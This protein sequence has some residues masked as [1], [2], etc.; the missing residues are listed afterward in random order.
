MSVSRRRGTMVKLVRLVRCCFLIAVS[1]IALQVNLGFASDDSG[2]DQTPKPFVK[3]A[4]WF[5]RSILRDVQ[6]AEGER[7]LVAKALYFNCKS[8]ADA[9]ADVVAGTKVQIE[10]ALEFGKRVLRFAI[11]RD[12]ISRATKYWEIAQ[13]AHNKKEYAEAVD[14]YLRAIHYNGEMWR[15]YD[16]IADI[17]LTPVS[18]FYSPKRAFLMSRLGLLISPREPSLHH[19]YLR[20]LLHLKL[21]D[22]ALRSADKAMA[23]SKWESAGWSEFKGDR[24]RCKLVARKAQALWAQKRKDAAERYF[25]IAQ[26]LDKYS[27]VKWVGAFLGGSYVLG[28]LGFGVAEDVPG[29]GELVVESSPWSDILVSFLGETTQKDGIELR[30]ASIPAGSY[31]VEGIFGE[32]RIHGIVSIESGKATTVRIDFESDSLVNLS[33][34][35][36]RSEAAYEAAMTKAR[37]AQGTGNQVEVV[38]Q[39]LLALKEK[40]G[41]EDALGLVSDRSSIP[42]WAFAARRFLVRQKTEGFRS[43]DDL[44]FSWDLDSSAQVGDGSRDAYDGGMILQVSGANVS[45]GKRFLTFDKNE[46]YIGPVEFKGLR[47]TRRAYIDR[48]RGFCRWMYMLENPGD[49]QISDLDVSVYT[50]LGVSPSQT[51]SWPGAKN[52][53]SPISEVF[54]TDDGDNSRPS[55]VHWVRGSRASAKPKVELSGDNIYYKYKISLGPGGRIVLMHAEGQRKNFEEAKKAVDEISAEHLFRTLDAMAARDLANW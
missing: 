50:N 21:Y 5:Y 17:Y 43:S 24:G 16:K 13:D 39:A 9:A 52:L 46:I 42:A 41:D 35:I 38:R 34:E 4:D 44:G 45:S 36:N 20:S 31:S 54:I 6:N 55:T 32:E 3:V 25:K 14:C 22:Q 33:S 53:V 7:E 19:S 49:K 27:D 8:S 37:A 48:S 30:F 40:P 11:N 29:T 10:D 12:Y 23:I 51:M 2:T 1:V 28:E 47:V 15:A 18:G 26:E